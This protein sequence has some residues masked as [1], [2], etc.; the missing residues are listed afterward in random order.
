MQLLAAAGQLPDH[1]AARST[2][3]QILLPDVR[4]YHCPV[5][6]DPDDASLEGVGI[7]IDRDRCKPV[8]AVMAWGRSFKDAHSDDEKK[9]KAPS[10]E[11]AKRYPFA[12]P[13]RPELGG[14]SGIFKGL[15]LCVGIGV[16][17][18]ASRDCLLSSDGV[19][20]WT[21]RTLTKLGPDRDKRMRFLLQ[22][23]QLFYS[24]MMGKDAIVDGVPFQQ[25][26]GPSRT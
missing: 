20:V 11:F 15:T 9:S 12:P 10:S 26:L 7:Y 1:V 16:R 2:D 21:V 19:F 18:G 22:M 8:R 25:L 4:R 14:W 23:M 24:L 17:A 3:E 13:R 5:D 6:D